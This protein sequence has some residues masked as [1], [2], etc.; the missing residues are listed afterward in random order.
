M[1]RME[2]GTYK[3][4]ITKCSVEEGGRGE[5]SSVCAMEHSLLK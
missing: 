3:L 2:Y 5:M 1:C 4:M